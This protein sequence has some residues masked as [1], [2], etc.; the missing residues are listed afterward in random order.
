M[1]FQFRLLLMLTAG[2]MIAAPNLS[3]QD[4]TTLAGRI[5]S[6]AGEPL[7][8]ASIII[9]SMN[10]GVASNSDGR[11]VLIVPA[12][13]ATGQ[14]VEMSVSM[15]GRATDAVQV[16]LRPGTQEF[17]FSLGEDPLLLDEIVVIGQAKC[18]GKSSASRSTRYG[19]KRSL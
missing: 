7:L 4:P 19:L 16:T 15:I 9:P 3:A 1:N 2:C 5:T 18:S 12:S 14:T 10:I 11:Y 6:S 13:R 17:D 8:G